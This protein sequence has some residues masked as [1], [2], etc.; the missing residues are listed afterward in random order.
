MKI[1]EIVVNTE[2]PPLEEGIACGRRLSEISLPQGWERIRY[3]RGNR[4]IPVLQASHP[5]GILEIPLPAHGLQ[6]IHLGLFRPRG[7]PAGMQ[8][9]LSTERLWRKIQPHLYTD[10]AG[11]AL[12][13]GLLGTKD[14]QAGAT[15]QVR[16]EPAGT[17]GIAYALCHPAP[18]NAPNPHRKNV[19]AVI[20]VHDVFFK[21]RIDKPDDLLGVLEPFAD[22][23]FDRICWG[24]GAG[25]FRA[26]YFSNVMPMLGDGITEYH[27]D[28]ARVTAE[29]MSMFRREGVDPLRLVNDFVHSLGLQLWSDDRICHCMDPAERQCAYLMNDFYINN[30][31]MR[32]LVM[33]GSPHHQAM[34]SLA[35]PEYRDLKIR[36]LAEQARYGVDGIYI[37]FTRK[38]PMVGWEAPVL[39]SFIKIYRKDPRKLPAS[40]WLMEWLQHQC[41]FVTEFMRRLRETLDLAGKERGCR[42]PVACQV[43]HG[44][45]FSRA[46]SEA[47]FNAIDIATWAREGLVDI[48]A[49]SADLWH[50]PIHLDHMETLVAGTACELWGCLHQ[51]AGECYPDKHEADA[52]LEA[53]TDPW[54]IMRTAADLY[55]QGAAG[56]FLWESGEL[57]TVPSRWEV[58]KHLGDRDGLRQAFGVPIGFCDGRHRNTDLRL[59]KLN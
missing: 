14:I 55:N 1:K 18:R 7:K 30:Q 13:D 5:A 25:S 11:N 42:I 10:D 56:L 51:R 50:A 17:A 9:K 59:D 57:A 39:E 24:N 15:L 46:I 40:E 33:D 53:H 47:Y 28:S 6:H 41:G 20:D 45:Q 4:E 21:Y 8:V 52:N 36:F 32:V 31:H 22:S 16:T 27:R 29:V 43:P 44:W 54:L 49:P 34:L 3:A 35:F 38:S 26:V 48:V 37:D 19:G 12:Q 2:M 58:L 23:D